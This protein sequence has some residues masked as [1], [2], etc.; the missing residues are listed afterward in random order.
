[1]DRMMRTGR[2]TTGVWPGLPALI[3]A[4]AAAGSFAGLN[5]CSDGTSPE[6]FSQHYVIEVDS[7]A[8]PATAAPGDT[9]AVRFWGWVGPNACHRFEGF[10]DELRDHGVDLTLWTHYQRRADQHCEPRNVWLE[11]EIYRVGPLPA[12]LFTVTV[13]Q[14]DGSVLVHETMVE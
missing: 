2:R 6:A 12:G 9:L 5:G 4:A 10:E 13:H 14:P 3:L 1:M 11:G 7:L 8:A